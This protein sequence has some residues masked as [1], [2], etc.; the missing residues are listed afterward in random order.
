MI[1]KIR[2]VVGK[3]FQRP[4]QVKETILDSP[5]SLAYSQMVVNNLESKYEGQLLSVP[6][7]F[8]N[9]D[10]IL[11]ALVNM[12]HPSV[13]RE[14]TEPYEAE[15]FSDFPEEIAELISDY[16]NVRLKILVNTVIQELMKTDQLK[17]SADEDGV[18]YYTE[19]PNEDIDG[20]IRLEK[21][22]RSV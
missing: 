8:I 20:I 14:L 12:G 7:Q 15:D 6:I 17:M 13:G 4:Q 10:V 2:E 22:F 19:E 1:N 3:L 11:Q 9:F 18:K 5:E 16:L 21:K